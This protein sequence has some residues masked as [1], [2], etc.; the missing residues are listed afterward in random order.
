MFYMLL[1]QPST[2]NIH[3]IQLDLFWPLISL[4][5]SIVD[6]SEV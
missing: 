1:L 4:H 5:Q 2:S 3:I 6:C